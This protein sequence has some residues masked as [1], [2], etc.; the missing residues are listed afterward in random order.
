M[1]IVNDPLTCRIVFP[2][3]RGRAQ[4]QTSGEIPIPGTFTNAF[5][6]LVGFCVEYT[7]DNHHLGQVE[8]DLTTARAG[9]G[10]VQVTGHL[11]LRDFSVNV[12]SS[13]WDDPYH[14]EIRFAIIAE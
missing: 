4:S 13:P 1:F 5:A 6:V 10:S 14:G 9:T 2:S 3:L 8:I 11:A 7:R 12:D